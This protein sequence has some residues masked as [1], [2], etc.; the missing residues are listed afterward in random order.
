MNLRK[1]LLSKVVLITIFYIITIWFFYLGASE[2]YNSTNLFSSIRLFILLLFT[3]IL[4]KYV[5]YLFVAPFYPVQKF[6][7]LT[8]YG[9]LYYPSV[10]VLISA[11][12]E[13]VGIALTISSVIRTNY[14][15]LEIIIVNDGSTDSTDKIVNAFIRNYL[16]KNGNVPIKYKKIANNG[17]SYALNRGLSMARNEIIVTI[18]AD[19]VMDKRFIGNIVTHFINP[20]VAGVAGNVIIGN[21]RRTL[22]LLQQL[23]YLY[24]FYFKRADSILSA[25]YIVGGA[26]AAYRKRVIVGSGGF[27]ENIITEDIELSTRLQYLG[28]SVK[29]ADNA[30]VYTEGPSD[31]KSLIKQRL[32]WKYGRLM[33]FYK[34][35]RLFFSLDK[36]HNAYLSF[37]ILPIALFNELL[38]LMEYPLLTV[39]YFYTFYTNDFFPLLFFIGFLTIV[40]VFQISS[41][42]SKKYH[43]NLLPLAPIAWLLFYVM[44]FVEFQA[45]VKSIYYITTK[46][47]MGWQ[48]WIRKGVFK[49]GMG[50]DK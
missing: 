37:L 24:G 11:H 47:R 36:K 32:R 13:E 46:K 30:V 49:D 1:E 16:K 38:L 31:M 20:K 34:Y 15:R 5:L 26:A 17:K 35:R 22:G 40:I 3:P 10:S 50:A 45:I 27:D 21:K 2:R 8:K 14:P 19:S 44:D 4:F 39:F 48:R 43:K 12:N 9:R 29:Y 23:E 25:V 28:Y 6:F 18:D 33:T 42:S 7:K 41:D